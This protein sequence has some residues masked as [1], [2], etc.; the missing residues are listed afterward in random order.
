MAARY[1]LQEIE[2]PHTMRSEMDLAQTALVE[3][4]QFMI[5]NVDYSTLK[6]PE[7]EDCC[8]NTR[9]VATSGAKSG[10]IPVAYDFDSSGIINAPYATLPA[11]VPIKKISTRYF[12]GWCKEEERYREAVERINAR[13]NEAI[14]LFQDSPLLSKVY[15]KRAV[16]Y[17]EDSYDDLNNED[18]FERKILGQCRGEVIKG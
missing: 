2:V 12:L 1:G 5:G 3:V 10:F 6:S 7:G 17:L 18:Y 13:K 4:F 16:R 14:D 15:R 9:L 8:H 11:N